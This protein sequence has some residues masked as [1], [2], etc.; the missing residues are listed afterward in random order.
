MY[1]L[2]YIKKYMSLKLNPKEINIILNIFKGAQ[3]EC[4][5]TGAILYR[6]AYVP[7]GAPHTYGFVV[8][9]SLTHPR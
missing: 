7:A 6:Y 2:V 1:I 3:F 5:A 4:V 8:L 9:T